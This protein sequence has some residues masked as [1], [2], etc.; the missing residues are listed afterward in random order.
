[1]IVLCYVQ[2]FLHPK[3][4][5]KSH[6]F[7]NSGMEN[8]FVKNEKKKSIQVMQINLQILFLPIRWNTVFFVSKLLIRIN[9]TVVS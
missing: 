6:I 9:L 3:T 8:T 4:L 2:C 7:Q 5:L 1:M